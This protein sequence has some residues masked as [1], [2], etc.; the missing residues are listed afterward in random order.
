MIHTILHFYNLATPTA[1]RTVRAGAAFLAGAAL[2]VLA[3]ACSLAYA[4]ECVLSQSL[5]AASMRVCQPAPVALK[6]ATTS[7]ES[8][9][10]VGTLVG[11][12]CGPRSPGLRWSAESFARVAGS[13]KSEAGLALAKSA[14]VHSGESASVATAALI[15][16]SSCALGSAIKRPDLVL[17]NCCGIP[18]DLSGV[19]FAQADDAHR[20]FAQCENQHIQPVT[21]QAHGLKP[22]LTVLVAVV[23]FDD[24]RIPFKALRFVEPDPMFGYVG[25]E[26][27]G[28]M[29]VAHRFDC[30]DKKLKESGLP[31]FTYGTDRGTIAPKPRGPVLETPRPVAFASPT[32][33]RAFV[34]PKISRSRIAGIGMVSGGMGHTAR[35]AARLQA[36]FEHP[37]HLLPVERQMVDS[38]GSPVGTQTMTATPV[39]CA[40][41]RTPTNNALNLEAVKTPTTSEAQAFALL[42]ATSDATMAKLYLAKGNIPAARRKV[43]QLLKALQSL[44]VA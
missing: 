41:A 29:G 19:G 21:N 16:A 40:S 10:V 9:M 5:S 2:A 42:Q 22:S 33:K 27:F 24:G 37:A 13:K 1:R 6:A 12:F 32:E 44:E 35:L 34:L 17:M 23:C 25:R 20:R 38:L 18:F 39:A 31:A 11:A 36:C 8:R 28:V 30:S 43:V 15:A 14:S 3:T 7:G 26:L 4:G